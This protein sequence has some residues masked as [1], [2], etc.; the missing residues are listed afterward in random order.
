MSGLVEIYDRNTQSLKTLEPAHYVEFMAKEFQDYSNFIRDFF[1]SKQN[2]I[3]GIYE[4]IRGNLYPYNKVSILDT[5]AAR[6]MYLEYMEGMLDFINH[7]LDLKDTDKVDPELVQAKYN[8]M[9]ELNDSFINALFNGEKISI[10]PNDI[11]DAMKSV[12]TLIDVNNDFNKFKVIISDI[13]NKYNAVTDTYKG[14]ALCGVKF[15]IDSVRFYNMKV[16]ESILSSY[17]AI[18]D[19]M[20]NRTPVQGVQE[21]PKYQV[22]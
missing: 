18:I 22:F 21:T 15:F 2:E 5:N 3:R 11:N 14:S 19:S 16:I 8:E 10:E 6:H 13:V 17:Q 4:A 20:K 12:E 1:I 7:N 9:S